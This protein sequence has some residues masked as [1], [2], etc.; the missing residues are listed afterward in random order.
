MMMLGG[1]AAHSSR[2]AQV[3]AENLR[4]DHRHRVKI[5]RLGQ[6]RRHGGQEQD[7]GDAVDEHGQKRRHHHKA[8]QQRHRPVMH[9]LRDF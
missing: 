8:D 6:L 3:G 9:Q 7:H 5:Q 4:Q 1:V 2:A